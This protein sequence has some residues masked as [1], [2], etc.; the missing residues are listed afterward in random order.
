MCLEG[1]IHHTRPKLMCSA[2]EELQIRSDCDLEERGS[3]EDSALTRLALGPFAE[4]GQEAQHLG[5]AEL[6]Q[7]C[8][9]RGA[10]MAA[11]HQRVQAYFLWTGRTIQTELP[12]RCRSR[13]AAILF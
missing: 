13:L 11:R 12:S 7:G 6:A 8:Q 9:H 10:V 1:T 3:D 5:S 4:V 2:R